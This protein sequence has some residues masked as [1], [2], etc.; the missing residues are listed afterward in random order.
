MQI[1]LNSDRKQTSFVWRWG[2]AY[3][4]LKINFQG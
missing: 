4:I 3:K 1:N 2:G